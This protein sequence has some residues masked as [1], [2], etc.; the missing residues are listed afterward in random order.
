MK[1]TPKKKK[2]KLQLGLVPKKRCYR[3]NP[4]NKFDD[5]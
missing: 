2:K 3:N 1:K 4:T 5:Y